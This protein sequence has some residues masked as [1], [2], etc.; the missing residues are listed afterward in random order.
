MKRYFVCAITPLCLSTACQTSRIEQLEGNLFKQQVKVIELEKDMGEGFDK[1]LDKGNQVQKQSANLLVQI[2]RMEASKQHILGEL[3]LLKQAVTTGEIPGEKRVDSIAARIKLLEI[4]TRNLEE[5]KQSIQKSY[6]RMSALDKKITALEKTQI[7]ILQLFSKIEKI[8]AFNNTNKKKKK[9]ET[10]TSLAKLQSAFKKKQ[11]LYI[12]EDAPAA[13]KKRK[14]QEF[15]DVKFIYAESIFKLGRISDA[16]LVF[17]ELITEKYNK[18]YL[19]KIQLRMGDCFRLLGDT[20]AALVYYE[21]LIEKHPH[22]KEVKY[23]KKYIPRLEK[24]L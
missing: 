8:Q 23:A 12:A 10:L 16:A 17:N 22:A 14:G 20:K 4:S 18:R 9:R 3:D 7:E 19:P 2:D 11:Y 13:L 6:S 15:T 24:K 21:E 5:Q 1:T